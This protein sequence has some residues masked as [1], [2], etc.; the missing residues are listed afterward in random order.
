MPDWTWIYLV[1]HG[2]TDWNREMRLQ[3]HSDTPLNLLGREQAACL[4]GRLRSLLPAALYSSDLCRSTETARI[5]LFADR[6]GLDDGCC[7]I[8]PALRE[9]HFGEWEGLTR[10]EIEERSPDLYRRWIAREPGFCYPGAESHQQ[11][12][13]RVAAI[14][15]RLVQEH[16]GERV[17]LFSHGGAILSAIGYALGTSADTRLPITL[18]NASLSAICHAEGRWSLA[19]VNDTCHAQ[20]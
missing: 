5:A 6:A 13:A 3:G 11:L 12:R 19:F 20:R 16:G 14:L 7:R 2:E 9:R 15:E 4:T 1:R 17:I 10:Q 18:A 8:T